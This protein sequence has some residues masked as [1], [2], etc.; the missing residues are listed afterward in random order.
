MALPATLPANLTELQRRVV[1]LRD[2]E[3]LTW[4][5]I[6]RQLGM[7][8]GNAQTAYTRAQAK[9]LQAGPPPTQELQEACDAA[10][11]AI[12]GKI[13]DKV[14]SAASAEISYM[15]L[16]RLAHDPGIWNRASVKDLAAVAGMM[17][18]KRQLLRG[19]PT[20]VI[21]IQDV[22]KLDE[23]AKALHE[24]MERRGML[25]DVTPEK[26]DASKK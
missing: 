15:A 18:D 13:D 16:W 8:P 23:M 19:E 3:G 4:A 25:V 9:M 1:R 22:R 2:A 5:E 6:G 14:L 7:D 12:R 26:G 20:Q 24:E 17:V 21:K 10:L 11:A